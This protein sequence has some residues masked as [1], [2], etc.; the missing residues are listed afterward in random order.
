MALNPMDSDL[1]LDSES[2]GPSYSAL[3]H[4]ELTA[5]L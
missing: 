1:R 3:S 2:S 4:L 5:Q